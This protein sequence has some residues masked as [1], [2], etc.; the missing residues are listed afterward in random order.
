MRNTVKNAKKRGKPIQFVNE[1]KHYIDCRYISSIEAAYRLFSFKIQIKA[2]TVIQLKV[3]LPTEVCVTYG[4]DYTI[5]QLQHAIDKAKK[6]TLT[7]FFANNQKETDNP[8]T[9][10]ERGYD[11]DGNVL[12]AGPDLLYHQYPEYYTYNN[13]WKRRKHGGIKRAIGRMHT[14]FPSQGQRWYLRR[15]LNHV[16]GPTSYIDL[17][18][19]DE[20]TFNCF[21]QRCD[22]QGLLEDDKEWDEA[23][24]E[25]KTIDNAS[26]MRRLFV[27]ILKECEVID[28]VQLWDKYKNDMI[29]DMVHRHKNRK[30]TANIEIDDMIK[31]SMFNTVLFEICSALEEHNRHQQYDEL[32]KLKPFKN[33]CYNDRNNDVWIEQ[34]YNRSDCKLDYENRYTKMNEKQKQVFNAISD[35][36]YGNPINASYNT[37]CFFIDAPGGTGKTF[38]LNA[39]LSL[40]RSH[41]DIALACASSGIAATNFPG[42][43]TVHSRFKVPIP[44]YDTS[45]N[46]LP[47]NVRD[48]LAQTK[49]I[50]V[51]EAPMQQKEI[52]EYID[53]TLQD[54]NG[55]QG[56]TFSGITFVAAGDFRQTAPIIPHASHSQIIA[57]SLSM[58]KLWK[59]FNV[60]YLTENERINQHKNINQSEKEKLEIWRDFL[61]EIGEG[62][63]PKD[64]NDQIKIPDHLLFSS[65]NETDLIN[66]V[67]GKLEN[68][69]VNVFNESLLKNAILTATNDNMRL[70]NKQAIDNFP[71]P[72]RTYKSIDS[73][74]EESAAWYREEYLNSITLNC[75]PD[76]ILELKV[77]SP[78]MVLRNIDPLNQVCNGT[79]GVV[80]RMMKYIIEIEYIS[81]DGTKRT[82]L[83]HRM[84][85]KSNE[86]QIP[87]SFYRLQYPICS[88]FAMTINKSQG[89]TINKVGIYLKDP[90]FSH[91]QLY[92]AL[93]R[94][95]HPDNIKMLIKPG[96]N[97]GK[98]VDKDGIYTKN[99]VFTELLSGIGVLP[100]IQPMRANYHYDE[101][102]V[103]N[104]DDFE[105]DIDDINEYISENTNETINNHEQ[106]ALAMAFAS[107]END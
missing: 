84:K 57:K 2:P 48:L 16:R 94:V 18:T 44:I 13:G 81:Y 97:Q 78:V 55:A 104:V 73:V 51:D 6:T 102:V 5:Q 8:L 37:N 70:L 9:D 101:F 64:D 74:P 61:L 30:L 42:G 40:V 79:Q 83:C 71:G 27:S 24:K 39:L 98:I 49:L 106:N 93:S 87:V 43:R 41:G 62:R 88:S 68:I 7:E 38:V 53:R 66:Y 12:P 91:G 47:Q 32:M 20:I 45:T 67:Y 100:C 25:S 77:G 96:D 21:K 58:S 4:A 1:I 15:L 56:K 10:D 75:F 76:H 95:T 59:Q 14:A 33:D 17:L 90:V 19:F 28:A 65:Q 85:L 60:L 50:I 54:I 11:V 35:S 34:Q 69:N 86:D 105:C 22:A 31:Q 46:D 63:Y 99:I 36:L 29:D 3:H 80:K 107:L 52:M 72:T 103:D 89:Q 23:M 26:Q 82:F 92:V